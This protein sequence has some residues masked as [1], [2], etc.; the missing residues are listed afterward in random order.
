MVFILFSHKRKYPATIK[1]GYTMRKKVKQA[2]FVNR[3]VPKVWA[4]LDPNEMLEFGKTYP[5]D[6]EWTFDITILLSFTALPN[7]FWPM[8][9]NFLLF[10]FF[11]KPCTVPA[12]RQV[13]IFLQ[14]L[15][16]FD[17]PYCF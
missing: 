12:F 9:S 10:S 14:E 11:Q 8:P 17:I 1:G 7:I 16:I 2:K 13:F 15:L 5:V 3:N 4:C 6:D